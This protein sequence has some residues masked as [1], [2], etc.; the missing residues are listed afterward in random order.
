MKIVKLSYRVEICVLL[1]YVQ[2]KDIVI[3]SPNQA[4]PNQAIVL[5][6]CEDLCMKHVKVDN[7]FIMKNY[8]EISKHL[9]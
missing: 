7:L 5:G 4:I 2:K 9:I 6:L 3:T 1:D 8:Y